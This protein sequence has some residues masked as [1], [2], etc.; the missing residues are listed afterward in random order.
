MASRRAK[1][2]GSVFRSAD[3]RWHARMWATDPS[4]GMRRRHHLVGASKADVARKLKVLKER[5]EQGQPA[6]DA[7]V[8]LAEYTRGWLA[9]TLP[10]SARKPTTQQLYAGLATNHIIGSELGRLG[11][12][13]IRPGSIERFIRQLRGKGLADSTVRQVYTI[14]RAI[15]DSAV[16]DGLIAANPFATV[17]RPAVRH[18][19]ATHLEPDELTRLLRAATETR[20]R[21]LFE[22]MMHT[23]LRRGEALALTWSSVDLP[24]RTLYVNGTLVRLEGILQV[25][26]P[27][28]RHSRRHVPL[29]DA[30]V[31]VLEETRARTALERQVAEGSWVDTGFV[32]TTE[33]GEPCEPRNALRALKA[34]A[35][36][37]GLTDVGLHTLRHSAATAMLAN[38]VPIVVVSRI[39]GHSGIE[40]TVDTY[41]HVAPHV[42]LEAVQTL[43][44][45]LDASTKPTTG[46]T[47]GTKTADTAGSPDDD[48]ATDQVDERAD[49]H[50]GEVVDD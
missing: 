22:L 50:D 31:R 25:Q 45:V 12:D 35:K 15:G 19:E 6:R 20:Y 47:A 48:P 28:T 46:A 37:A 5:L 27:K 44:Q 21:P 8:S 34:A 49:S 23:G 29:S 16:R 2:E 33:W 1:G 26:P 24:R 36:A 14:G 30:A 41:G 42:S 17:A 3:G 38:G 7:A 9:E 10:A 4:S 43:G 13:Q 40:I 18:R 39:L 32:F 11:L